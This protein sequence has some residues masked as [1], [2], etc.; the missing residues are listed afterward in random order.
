MVHDLSTCCYG[1]AACLTA[2]CLAPLLLYLYHVQ[3][4]IQVR[5]MSNR[6]PFTSPG[7]I[8]AQSPWLDVSGC[9][10]G[11]PLLVGPL[12]NC[13]PSQL[14]NRVKVGSRRPAPFMPHNGKR[15]MVQQSSKSSPRLST[16]FHS[17]SPFY[18]VTVSPH[19]L[20]RLVGWLHVVPCRRFEQ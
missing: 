4:G 13:V 11:F 15:P 12:K 8:P 14:E 7:I 17:S 1:A 10:S 18:Q 5:P 16:R 3:N 2:S 9:S 20:K 6:G 19:P